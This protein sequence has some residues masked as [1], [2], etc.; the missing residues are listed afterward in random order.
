M[1][2]FQKDQQNYKEM[3]SRSSDP[4]ANPSYGYP[5]GD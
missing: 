2:I 1:Q 3:M 4:D 5:I